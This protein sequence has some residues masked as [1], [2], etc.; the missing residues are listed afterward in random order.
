NL[1]YG[2]TWRGQRC[3]C[4]QRG[5]HAAC[6]EKQIQ[7]TKSEERKC[8]KNHGLRTS[9]FALRSSY[10]AFS[11]QTCIRFL[12]CIFPVLS[13]CFSRGRFGNR[14]GGSRRPSSWSCPWGSVWPC[15]S[16]AC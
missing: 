3:T 2:I 10:F 6:L 16:S 12:N 5:S 15:S 9:L 8:K 7:S 11:C 14:A 1:F 13:S 4:R